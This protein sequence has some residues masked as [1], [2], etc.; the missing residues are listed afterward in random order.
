M[1]ATAATRAPRGA[2]S[3]PLP[4]TPSENMR[5]NTVGVCAKRLVS[6][7]KTA[8]IVDAGVRTCS[9][10][11]LGSCLA[12]EMGKREGR[13]DAFER[14]EVAEDHRW[15]AGSEAEDGLVGLAPFFVEQLR[16]CGQVWTRRTL[17]MRARSQ[18]NTRPP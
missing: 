6:T 2:V 17:R 4:R 14:A 15:L 8:C 13:T 1:P 11:R 5:S 12:G 16:A 10:E 7:I 18:T 9:Y 3:V